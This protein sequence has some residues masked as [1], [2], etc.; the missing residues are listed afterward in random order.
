MDPAPV[1]YYCACTT[2]ACIAE[3]TSAGAVCANCVSG[4]HHN[5][6]NG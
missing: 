1:T 2:C 4:A 3:V 6:R 5:M